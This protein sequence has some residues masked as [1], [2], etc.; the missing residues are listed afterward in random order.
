MKY[1]IKI[2]KILLIFLLIIL[3][4]IVF[5]SLKKNKIDN[6]E[7]SKYIILLGDSILNNSNYVNE[8]MSVYERIKNKN[9]NTYL[10]AEDGATINT[11]DLQIE[12]LK[13]FH[14]E[15]INNKNTY[16]FISIGGND[17]LE[18]K[19]NNKIKLNNLLN[20]YINKIKLIKSKYP[21]T[22]I[23]IL[24]LYKPLN[25]KYEKYYET[26]DNWN[27]LLE[28]EKEKNKIYN[29]L[30]ISKIINNTSDLTYSIEPSNN[31]SKKIAEEILNKI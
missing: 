28:K 18:K 3:F 9:I 30:D 4:L 26:I 16:I 11:L 19:I 21:Q 23:Y 27:S 22:N 7:N 20:S 2:N 31:G 24:N 15:K 8:N 5:L 1:Y 25:S 14:N 6:F 29:I 13:E 10:L 17:I 12:K